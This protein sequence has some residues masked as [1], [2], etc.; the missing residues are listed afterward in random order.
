MRVKENIKMDKSL[1]IDFGNF[2]WSNEYYFEDIE[3]WT[4]TAKSR[5]DK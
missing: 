5:F 1:W 3:F 2:F 4:N